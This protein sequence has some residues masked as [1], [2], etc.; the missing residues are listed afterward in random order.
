MTTRILK[1]SQLQDYRKLVKDKGVSE[2]RA[3]FIRN[4]KFASDPDWWR[5][6]STAIRAELAKIDQEKVE[7][8]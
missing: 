3:I 6:N 7:E 2:A 8:R 4:L 1:E 5:E